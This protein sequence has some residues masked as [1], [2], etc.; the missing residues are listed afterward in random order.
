MVQP[1]FSFLLQHGVKPLQ[2]SFNELLFDYKI[3]GM[4]LVNSPSAPKYSFIA[5]EGKRKGQK[6]NV[7]YKEDENLIEHYFSSNVKIYSDKISEYVVFENKTFPAELII[8]V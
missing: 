4:L 8:G 5:K 7:Y 6:T 3:N 1:W 2:G